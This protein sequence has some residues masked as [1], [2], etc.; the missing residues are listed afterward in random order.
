MMSPSGKHSL[1]SCYL[2][3]CLQGVDKL[4]TRPGDNVTIVGDDSAAAA[5]AY[6]SQLEVSQDGKLSASA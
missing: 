1:Y 4:V 5:A 3:R 2:L 6:S